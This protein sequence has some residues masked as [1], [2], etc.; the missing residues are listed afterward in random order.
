ME[1]AGIEIPFSHTFCI[2][3]RGGSLVAECF[4]GVEVGGADGGDHAADQAGDDQD[5]GGD[6]DRGGR[7]DELDI[8]VFGVFGDGAVKGD[9]AD[10]GG[11]E[12]GKGDAGE[13]TDPGDGQSFGNADI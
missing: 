3:A 4:D 12:I 6:D 7:N 8:G 5:D 11:D 1:L 9:A 2:R 13:S 10:K